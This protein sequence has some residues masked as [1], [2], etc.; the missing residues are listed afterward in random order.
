L[1]KSS[2]P[3]DR[4]TLMVW[5]FTAISA[6]PS[7]QTMTRLTPAQMDEANK[8]AALVLQRLLTQDCRAQTVDAVRYE[9]MGAIQQSFSVVGQVAMSSLMQDPAVSGQIQGMA[10]YLDIQKFSGLLSDL[11][12]AP[13]AAAPKP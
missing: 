7:V 12:Q 6:H 3:A 13:A 10:K 1:V 11:G 4:S 9:S 2:S 8:N 5:L